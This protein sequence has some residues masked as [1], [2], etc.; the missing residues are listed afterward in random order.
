MRHSDLARRRRAAMP[1]SRRQLLPAQRCV[2]H[3]HLFRLLLAHE[4]DFAGLGVVRFEN[5]TPPS[6]SKGGRPV[7]FAMHNED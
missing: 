6:G 3:R 1:S 7:R 4:A 5:A 2:A